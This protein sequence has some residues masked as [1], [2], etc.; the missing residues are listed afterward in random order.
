VLGGTYYLN[1]HLSS[2]LFIVHFRENQLASVFRKSNPV[3]NVTFTA[4]EKTLILPCEQ[5]LQTKHE[6]RD[7]GSIKSNEL[8]YVVD[9][10]HGS[11]EIDGH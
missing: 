2:F 11:G 8:G 4:M 3:P 7:V 9:S 5:C 6:T 1:K 10:P